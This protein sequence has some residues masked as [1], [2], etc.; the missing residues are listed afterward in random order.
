[1]VVGWVVLDELSR[2]SFATRARRGLSFAAFR[3]AFYLRRV[4]AFG[5]VFA[6]VNV[7]YQVDFGND[8]YQDSSFRVG[9]FTFVHRTCP[10]LFCFRLYLNKD[11]P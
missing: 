5:K 10:I 6:L 9:V 7:L 8:S 11:C 2:V 1:M 4:M 3:S